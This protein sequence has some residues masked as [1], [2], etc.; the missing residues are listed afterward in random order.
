[1]AF[2]STVTTRAR[3]PS[4]STPSITGAAPLV[5]GRAVGWYYLSLAETI[6]AF[7]KSHEGRSSLVECFVTL[8]QGLK[9]ANELHDGW[10]LAM[11]QPYLGAEGNYM[12]SS[13]DAMFV[14]E[15]LH[16]M[17]TG[18][19]PEAEYGELADR[20]FWA[21]MESF[22]SDKKD[23]T[24]DLE[25]TVEIGSLSSIGTYEVS[26]EQGSIDTTLGH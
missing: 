10:W 11:R 19:L 3:L 18:L 22:V 26:N 2:S 21:M 8:S 23:G 13:A 12:E 5:W 6:E 4:R 16:G 24:L 9:E 20:S 15:L 25:E 7:P 14:Y 1:M 17:R